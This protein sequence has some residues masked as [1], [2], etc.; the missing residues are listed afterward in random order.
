MQDIVSFL[1]AG[2]DF[3]GEIE[4]GTEDIWWMPA[5]QNYPRLRWELDEH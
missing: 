2:W 4:N 1:N 3:T 5:G